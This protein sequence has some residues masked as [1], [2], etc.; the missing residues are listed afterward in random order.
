MTALLAAE[1]LCLRHAR[2][3]RDSLR[4]VGIE[5]QP[6]EIVALVGPNGSGKSSLLAALAGWLLPRSGRVLFRGRDLRRVDRREYAR[7]VASL[8]QEPRAP[9]G[10]TV[11]ALVAHGRN[12]HR[13]WLGAPSG[14][15]RE[16]IQRALTALDLADF[17]TR[18][19][20]TLS[21]GERRRAWLA[22]V[23]A[24]EAEVLLLDEPTAALDLRQQWEVIQLLARVRSEQG[25]TIV[26]ALHDLEHA[27]ALAQRIALLHRGR[28]YDFG[29]P[30]RCLRRSALSDVFGIDADVEHRAG[31]TQIRVRG[32]ASPTR[33]L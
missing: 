7:R 3:D 13:S 28:L 16:A 29:S 10:L 19:I 11:E 31:A 1:H 17:R 25:R 15:D 24:Q 30:S 6:G 33:H 14:A 20:E 27:G 2:A 8:P 21:G 23:L 26:L 18:P 12:P 22:M 9:E 32:P 5:V 4:D